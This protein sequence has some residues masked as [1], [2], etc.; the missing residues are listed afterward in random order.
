MGTCT[1]HFDVKSHRQMVRIEVIRQNLN[2]TNKFR[3]S[4][5]D[6]VQY[7]SRSIQNSC[8]EM[9]TLR[10]KVI[11][12]HRTKVQK[13]EGIEPCPALAMKSRVS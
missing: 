13:S 4:S 9:I 11:V 5:Q 10:Q 1:V 3:G 6:Q 12:K 2:I 8:W 7:I